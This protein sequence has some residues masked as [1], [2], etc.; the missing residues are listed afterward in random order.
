LRYLSSNMAENTPERIAIP[1]LQKKLETSK[2]LMIVDV[3]TAKEIQESGAVPNAIHVPLEQVEL[4]IQEFPKGREVVF[5]CGGGGRA[6]RAA[7]T[8]WNS[9]HRKVFYFGGNEGTVP[10]VPAFPSDNAMAGMG[11]PKFANVNTVWPES[12]PANAQNDIRRLLILETAERDVRPEIHANHRR[13]VLSQVFF[14]EFETPSGKA[15]KVPGF[16]RLVFPV[17]ESD[18]SAHDPMMQVDEP[19]RLADR[20]HRHVEACRL[21]APPLRRV[22]DTLQFTP[23]ILK[24]LVSYWNVVQRDV[25]KKLALAKPPLSADLK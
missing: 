5:Y 8:L 14:R 10:C 7:Q 24:I 25:R 4:H 11:L 23:E 22:H 19:V 18:S 9:G 16:L 21:Q 20:D 3:R 12:Q 15:M 2:T 13:A 6:S 1:D 17:Q